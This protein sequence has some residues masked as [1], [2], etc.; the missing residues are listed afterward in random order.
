VEM[1]NSNNEDEITEVISRLE[2]AVKGL[3]NV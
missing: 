1:V 2:E 3:E